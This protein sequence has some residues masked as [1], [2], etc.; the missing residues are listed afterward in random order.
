MWFNLAVILGFTLAVLTLNL[1][2]NTQFV[3]SPLRKPRCL[4]A[5]GSLSFVVIGSVFAASQPLL[6]GSLFL[7]TYFGILAIADPPDRP[8]KRRQ[9]KKYKMPDWAALMGPQPVLQT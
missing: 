4:S 5:V 1:G 2:R 9:R 7:W 6:F 8:K 3:Q